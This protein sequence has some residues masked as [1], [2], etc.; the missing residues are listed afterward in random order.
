MLFEIHL[1]FSTFLLSLQLLIRCIHIL[2][3]LSWY[4]TFPAT[5]VTPEENG[6]CVNMDY[7]VD[8]PELKN[9]ACRLCVSFFSVGIFFY[10]WCI[11][12]PVICFLSCLYVDN[13]SNKVKSHRLENITSNKKWSTQKSNFR[14]KQK[15]QQKNL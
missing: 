11:S 4:C 7:D 8:N 2:K 12:V 1:D 14:K 3:P 5:S 9:Q 6:C 15:K 10:C 13:Y